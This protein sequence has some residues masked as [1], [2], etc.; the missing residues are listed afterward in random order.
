VTAAPVGKYPN[1]RARPGCHEL[2]Q[3]GSG[4]TLDDTEAVAPEPDY[5]VL[6]A[7]QKHQTVDQNQSVR[8]ITLYKET[9]GS[10]R[11]P[12]ANLEGALVLNA[13]CCAGFVRSDGNRGTGIIYVRT[14]AARN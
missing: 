8:S 7:W 11:S 9:F 14:S 1:P 6:L 2:W 12:V 5:R 10:N 13:I 3:G 4:P